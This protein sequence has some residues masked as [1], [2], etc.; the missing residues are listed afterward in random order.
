MPTLQFLRG[1]DLNPN[2]SSSL[3]RD[4]PS[5]ASAPHPF[6]GDKGHLQGSVSH[7]APAPL[8]GFRVCAESLEPKGPTESSAIY[9]GL[10]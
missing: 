8:E 5:T 10:V 1:S 3:L 7:T 4:H 2:S 6:L 9:R